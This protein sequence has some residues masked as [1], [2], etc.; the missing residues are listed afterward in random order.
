MKTLNLEQAAEL[1]MAS[2]DTVRDLIR[3]DGLPATKVGRAWVFVDVDLIDWLRSRYPFTK[4][5]SKECPSTSVRARPA[6]GA[7]SS[8]MDGSYGKALVLPTR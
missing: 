1:L 6:G 4:K 8:S 7:N 2:P 5:E 3:S